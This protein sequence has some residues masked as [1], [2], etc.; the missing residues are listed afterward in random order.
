MCFLFTNIEPHVMSE[1]NDKTNQEIGGQEF[2][3]GFPGASQENE[4][5]AIGPCSNPLGVGL[6]AYLYLLIC[7]FVKFVVAF[8]FVCYLCVVS[9]FI[10]C[11]LFKQ[12]QKVDFCSGFWSPPTV[13]GGRSGLALNQWSHVVCRTPIDCRRPQNGV[14]IMSFQS[15]NSQ[16][17]TE[18]VCLCFPVL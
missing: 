6:L 17:Q 2:N 4:R 9:L 16:R 8:L 7:W 1:F 11:S 13:L 18:N 14:D 5:L 3:G 10:C 15:I 12:A